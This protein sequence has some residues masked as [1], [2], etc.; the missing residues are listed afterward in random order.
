[1]SF[2]TGAHKC[3]A[4][5]FRFL[6]RVKVT[7]AENAPAE[8]PVVVCANHLSNHDVIVLASSLKR[9]V[10]FFAKAE[11]F[12]VPLLKQLVTALGAFPVDRKVATSA[13]GAIK[14]TLHILEGGEMIG[15]YPQ[16]TRH[17]GVDPRTTEVKGGIGMIAA[18]SKA[19]VL[20]VCIYTKKWKVGFFRRTNVVI[21]KPIPYEELG[22]TASRGAEYQRA[23]EYI[24]SKITDLIP[25]SYPDPRVNAN[26]DGEAHNGN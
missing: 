12:K 7:G 20:P 23:S 4:G 25:D 19:T 22:I 2:Y 18:K 13:A 3:L 5:F 17:P 15:L 10:R 24:F 16:G 9:P 1:M 21:G 11:L 14:Q 6:Y 8:G 26:P